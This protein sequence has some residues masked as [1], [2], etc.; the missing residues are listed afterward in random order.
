MVACY[1]TDSCQSASKLGTMTL[2]N[3]CVDA[4]GFSYFGRSGC[5]ICS[6]EHNCKAI[7]VLHVF[8][9]GALTIYMMPLY[10]YYNAV[11][12]WNVTN[13]TVTESSEAISVPLRMV[14]GSSDFPF[15]AFEVVDE[16]PPSGEFVLMTINNGKQVTLDN[17]AD[18][19]SGNSL[20]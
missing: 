9:L 4:D 20:P 13:L 19:E 16:T 14:K 8:R 12:G 10:N 7:E 18:F 6:G 11:Y 3:C 2:Q 17:G 5:T 1:A 15:I